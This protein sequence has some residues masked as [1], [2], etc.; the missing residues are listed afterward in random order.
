M[1]RKIARIALLSTLCLAG[2]CGLSIA[3]LFVPQ[4][5]HSQQELQRVPMG[6]PFTFIHQDL[7]GYTPL[8]WPQ[9]FRFNP[10]QEHPVVISVDWFVVDIGIFSAG[11]LG[12]VHVLRRL[13][14]RGQ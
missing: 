4:T 1:I 3:T 11:L 7:S 2:G 5:F 13:R 14:R 10:P 8:D 9:R 12:L 6:W